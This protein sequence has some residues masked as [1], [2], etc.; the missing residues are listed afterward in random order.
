[1]RYQNIINKLGI[2]DSAAAE[3]LDAALV[4]F[5]KSVGEDKNAM[6]W[7]CDRLIARESEG[8]PK[9]VDLKIQMHELDYTFGMPVY[10]ATPRLLLKV[11]EKWKNGPPTSGKIEHDE[12][13]PKQDVPRCGWGGAPLPEDSV[14]IFPNQEGEQ[15]NV[16]ERPVVQWSGVKSGE[17]FIMGKF[18]AQ[19]EPKIIEIME[20]VI[21]KPA[22]GESIWEHYEKHATIDDLSDIMIKLREAGFSNQYNTTEK[23]LESTKAHDGKQYSKAAGL[24][25]RDRDKELCSAIHFPGEVDLGFHPRELITDGGF[26]VA[27]KK[28][29]SGDL[30]YRPVSTQFMRDNYRHL[31]DDSPVVPIPNTIN[32]WFG[33]KHPLRKFSNEFGMLLKEVHAINLEMRSKG[34]LPDPKDIMP[35]GG[36]EPEHQ[37]TPPPL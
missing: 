11:P 31:I 29:K 20:S 8:R 27:I 12:V 21:G 10:S 4:R 2:T 26:S 3:K 17:Y 13:G 1:M 5:E 9:E 34:T 25:Y 7:V 14:I 16:A 28:V 32:I 36:K 37:P 35:Q 33:E 23:Y 22:K 15:K 19:D 30:D 18:L 6:G 24:Y